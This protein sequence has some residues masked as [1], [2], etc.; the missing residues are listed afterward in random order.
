MTSALG[1]RGLGFLAVLF[2]FSAQAA[3]TPTLEETTV[4]LDGLIESIKDEAVEFNREAQDIERTVLYPERTRTSIYVSNRI[5]QLVLHHITISIDGGQPV[6][7]DF[8]EA[9]AK[10]LL[11]SDGFY[12]VLM[13]NLEPG[14]HRI[15]ADIRG[16]FADD[17]PED[18]AV[19]ASFEQEFEKTRRPAEL[20]LRVARNTRISRAQI[21]LVDWK[22]E[23]SEDLKPK[24]KRR[25]QK[26]LT[27]K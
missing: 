11:I 1:P 4:K 2:S 13:T 22:V 3:S 26:R 12:R 25:G 17:A 21:G 16:R 18:P 14:P 6:R 8:S 27:P 20:E 10:A 23:G 9:S 19:V 15:K 5:S 7:H 24:P